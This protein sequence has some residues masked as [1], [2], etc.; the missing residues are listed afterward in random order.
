MQMPFDPQ[1]DEQEIKAVFTHISN[2]EIIKS[3]GEGTVIKATDKIL[4]RTVAIKIYG[5]DHLK[6]RSELEVKK[7]S[8]INLNSL[9]R[10]YNYGDLKIRGIDCY[11]IETD[12]INGYDLRK[13]L[14]DGKTLSPVDTAKMV[15]C[16]SEAI[17]CLW[18]HKVVHCDIKPENI[19]KSNDSYTLID[20]GIAKHL[21]V[22]TMTAA[23]MI[24]GTL[25][26]LAPEQFTGRKNLTLKADYYALGIAAY[27]LLTGYHPF[28]RNQMAML[29]NNVPPFPIHIQI[30]EALKELI[31]LLTNPVPYKR[32]LNHDEIL[33]N[34]KGV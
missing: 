2:V 15:R 34:L 4:N 29:T 11:F 1:L 32:P 3:G 19:I 5:P 31:Y 12:Y 23:G 30:P 24:M 8:L 13:I 10:L 16:I 25:G 14:D 33:M 28:N 18:K 20:L 26:Y 9:I 21:D 22:S 17:E 6:K 7:L 27:E